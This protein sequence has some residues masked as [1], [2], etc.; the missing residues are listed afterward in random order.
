MNGKAA[1]FTRARAPFEIR[2]YP[3]PDVGADAIV[4]VLSM[5]NICGSD[6]HFWKGRGPGIPQGINQILGHEMVG[7]IYA[8]GKN[9]KTDDLG[10][11]L[12]EGDRIVYSYFRPCGQCP[13]CLTGG[14][15]C[16]NRYRD[17]IGV[18]ADEFP[19]F[20]GAYGEYYYMEP[21]HW[22]FK[23]PD[24]LPDQVVSPL[25]CA[26]CESIYGMNQIGITLED[27]VVIQGAG[28][29]GLYAS[30]IAKEM[31]AGQVIVLDRLEDRLNLAKEFGADRVVN[32]IETNREQ[33]MELVH[34]LTRG[35]GAD[36]V[37][38]FTGVPQV[39]DEGL[40]L[41]RFG[42]RY[43][44]IGNINVGFKTNLDPA[45]VVRPNRTIKG[46]T[47][48]EK[49]V[50]PRAL[51]FLVRTKDKYPFHKIISHKFRF[52]QINE[53]FQFADDG[54]AIRV[55]LEF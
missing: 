32:V 40:K 43:L 46:I 21:G 47:A 34:D 33:R 53:A 38:E 16:P 54:R 4:V 11:P 25:N 52:D 8:L 42:G 3:V 55:A 15:A 28:G 37:A 22:V 35:A 5:S 41:L 1:I 20:N 12:K 23:V 49:W 27:T 36:V 19:H 44:W 31:G 39:I 50:M 9:V 29:L 10:Q 30:S 13:V 48:Y 45:L 6:L 26:L 2:E 51:D 7:T 18:P 24:E 17:W 14:P